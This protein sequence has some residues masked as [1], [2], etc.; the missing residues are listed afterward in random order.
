[1]TKKAFDKIA[2]GLDDAAA[3][4]RGDADLGG[5]R[6]HVPADVDVRAI[7]EHMGLT[8]EAFS[9]R[10]GF[11]KGTVRDWEQKRRRPEASARLLL[12]VIERRPDV[13]DEILG[14]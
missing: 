7:R 13:I 8:R 10:F 2:A 11:P 4:V 5:F 9:A 14:A 1:M 12:K 6:V 3:Y